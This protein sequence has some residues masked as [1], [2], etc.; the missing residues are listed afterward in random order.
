MLE[1]VRRHLAIYGTAHSA[2]R[3]ATVGGA[4]YVSGTVRHVPDLEEGRGGR[5]DHAALDLPAGAWYLAV[6][7][8]VPRASRRRR[9]RQAPA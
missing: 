3:V 4:V 2:T 9:V 1:R 6:R 8:T 7:N 5:R